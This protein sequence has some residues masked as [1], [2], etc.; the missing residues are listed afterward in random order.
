[1]HECPR[2]MACRT[3]IPYDCKERVPI[4]DTSTE[5]NPHPGDFP[6]SLIDDCSFK[7][8]F[9]NYSLWDLPLNIFYPYT[10]LKQVSI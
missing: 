2:Y 8:V 9:V 10:F 5:I 1:M 3:K 7:M 4:Q 6:A